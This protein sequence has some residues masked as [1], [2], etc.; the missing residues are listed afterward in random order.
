MALAYVNLA[1]K[2]EEAREI[3][4]VDHNAT[5][6]DVKKAYRKL[7][8]QYHSDRNPNNPEAEAKL[9]SVNNAHDEFTK[10]FAT[11]AKTSGAPP[12]AGQTRRASSR[13]A[14][15]RSARSGQR[16]PP[17][18]PGDVRPVPTNDS[19]REDAVPFVATSQGAASRLAQQHTFLL[20]HVALLAAS[21]VLALQAMP[22]F[23]RWHS[24][25]LHSANSS[26]NGGGLAA[27]IAGLFVAIAICVWAAGPPFLMLL[28][29]IQKSWVARVVSYLACAATVSFWGPVFR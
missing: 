8:R 4:G 10:H 7:A 9:K 18:P 29:A 28:T 27:P 24:L 17:P 25:F 5:E 3:L 21:F 13:P 6:A 23:A 2:I 15:A 22:T 11:R 26:V 14:G 16:P 19:P 1:M 12:G 20:L